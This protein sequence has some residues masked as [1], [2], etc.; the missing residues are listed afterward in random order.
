MAKL[1][2]ILQE[3]FEDT[4]KVDKHKVISTLRR[5]NVDKHSVISTL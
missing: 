4:P 5:H 1:K 2:D 3:V